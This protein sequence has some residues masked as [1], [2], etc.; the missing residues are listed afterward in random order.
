MPLDQPSVHKNNRFQRTVEFSKFW[1][2]VSIET[3]DMH[4]EYH[5]NGTVLSVTKCSSLLYKMPA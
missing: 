1:P 4:G 5:T 2:R 3:L